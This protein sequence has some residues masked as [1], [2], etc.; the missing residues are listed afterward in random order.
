[1][2]DWLASIALFTGA[3]A[4]MEGVACLT[5]RHL[6]H[7]PLWFLHRSHHVP[8]NGRFELNDLFGLAFAVPSIILI[9]LGV[10][11]GTWMLPVGLGMTTYG[12]LYFVFHDIVVHRRLRVRGVPQWPYLRRIIKAHL[13]HHRTLE[14]DGARSFGFL[15]APAAFGEAS[16]VTDR[17]ACP[18]PPA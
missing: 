17:P 5:H 14:R 15:Y 7:G 16:R 11:D 8:H 18:D 9:H 3:L 13:V 2:V 12:L 10:R 6:M 4:G 1:M